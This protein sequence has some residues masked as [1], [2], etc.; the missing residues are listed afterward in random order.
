MSEN[1]NV[2]PLRRQHMT[3]RLM[4]PVFILL[5]LE[6]CQNPGRFQAAFADPDGVATAAPAH[7]C[8]RVRCAAAFLLGLGVTESFSCSH[9]R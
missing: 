5:A 8:Q 3:S 6:G 7:S 2:V 4:V 9:F 1:I